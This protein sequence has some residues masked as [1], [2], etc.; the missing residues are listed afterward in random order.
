MFSEFGRGENMA[1]PKN[2]PEQDKMTVLLKV[3]FGSD[4]P[5]RMK[6]VSEYTGLPYL[7]LLQKWLTQEE[8][9][10]SILRHREEDLLKRIETHLNVP[11]TRITPEPQP[12]QDDKNYRQ[13]IYQRIIELKAQGMTFLKIAQLFNDEKTPTFSGTGKW[14]PATISKIFSAQMSV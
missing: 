2:V 11:E 8:A 5:E 3:P 7:R 13:E 4:L 1:R 10:I 14:Y 9:Q 12:E 6:N